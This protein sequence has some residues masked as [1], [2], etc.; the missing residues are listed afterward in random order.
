MYKTDSSTFF[1]HPQRQLRGHPL[2]LEKHYCQTKIWQNFFSYGIMEDWNALAPETAT[3]SSR[4]P[5]KLQ[6]TSE[7]PAKGQGG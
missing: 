3:A 1:T 6:E 7:I 2:K 5:G 4:V